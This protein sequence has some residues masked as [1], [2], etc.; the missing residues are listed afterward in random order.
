MLARSSARRPLPSLLT[1]LVALLLVVAQASPAFAS[2][3][4]APAAAP[5]AP[6]KAA[7]LAEHAGRPANTTVRAP[8]TLKLGR[9]HV[10]VIGGKRVDENGSVVTERSWGL[11]PKTG[12]NGETRG[13]SFQR[14]TTSTTTATGDKTTVKQTELRTDNGKGD[15]SARQW[16][17][18]TRKEDGRTSQ[19]KEFAKETTS[20]EKST[21]LFR[22]DASSRA[23]R[24]NW[25]RTKSETSS[26][27][28][29]GTGITT[30]A[31]TSVEEA[32]SREGRVR[33][34]VRVERTTQSVTNAQTGE[35]KLVGREQLAV[36][37]KDANG[38][39]K[40]PTKD[41]GWVETVPGAGEASVVETVAGRTAARIL[42]KGV[43]LDPAAPKVAAAAPEPSAEITAPAGSLHALQPAALP[44]DAQLAAAGIRAVQTKSGVRY[45]DI[46]NKSRFIAKD[47]V[48]R[49]VAAAPSGS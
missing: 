39:F 47:E 6:P 15:S 45:Q 12:E 31:S 40:V 35:A 3:P 42:K 32:A 33:D 4:N 17:T 13:L 22:L 36:R 28:D 26:E 49:R 19:V 21:S 20:A 16:Q 11:A 5:A 41:V 30:G 43:E 48:Q 25:E 46:A 38:R 10:D 9:L 27:T 18:V 23:G 7:I 44:T 8:V 1:L 29:H 2:G 24:G 14:A 37:G 34:R